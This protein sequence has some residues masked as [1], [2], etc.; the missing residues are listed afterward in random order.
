M[1]EIEHRD[2][3]PAVALLLPYRRKKLRKSVEFGEVSA[4]AGNRRVW[5]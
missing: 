1:A 4:A 2:G 3:G 5:V